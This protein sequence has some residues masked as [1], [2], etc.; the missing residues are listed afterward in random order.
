MF[1]IHYKE[2]I[3]KNNKHI[4]LLDTFFT[5]NY[6][7]NNWEQETVQSIFSTLGNDTWIELGNYEDSETKKNYDLE[8]KI[9]NIICDNNLESYKNKYIQ[10]YILNNNELILEY[11]EYSQKNI[12][13]SIIPDK[14]TPLL[15]YV[16]MTQTGGK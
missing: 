16:S 5:L 6:F 12:N 13:K 9:I 14:F 4:I 7:I 15:Q 8:A 11:I 1:N 10:Q 3:K 2:R